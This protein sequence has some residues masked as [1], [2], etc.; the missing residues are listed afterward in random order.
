MNPYLHPVWS[1]WIRG[2]HHGGAQA[3]QNLALHLYNSRDWP[4][5]LGYICSLSDDHWEAAMAMILDYRENGEENREFL[6][7][8]AEIA[9][10]RLARAEA[11]KAEEDETWQDE[12]GS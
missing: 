4:V 5:N 10:E 11:A 12:T 7:M 6:A 8:C 9:E 2:A 3:L 1:K